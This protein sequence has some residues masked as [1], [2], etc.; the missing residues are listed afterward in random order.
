MLQVS[1]I[2]QNIK[3]IFLFNWKKETHKGLEPYES[4]LMVS[5]WSSFL[6]F[7]KEC[8]CFVIDV[9]YMKDNAFSY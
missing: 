8:N 4:E 3:I 1:N 9:H 6:L 5:W 2:L 7:S